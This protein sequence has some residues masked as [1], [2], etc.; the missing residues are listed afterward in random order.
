MSVEKSCEDVTIVGN[1][2]RNGGRGSWI[3][4]PRNFILADNIFVNNTTKCEPDPRRGRRSFVTGEYERYPEL[5]F[6]T[7]EPD[8][9]YGNVIVRG[10][11]FTSGSYAKHAITFAPGG[12]NL[13]VTGN[14]FHGEV[15]D[16]APVVGCENVRIDH[17]MGLEENLR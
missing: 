4:Q 3:N 6:T 13:V 8:G 14:V 10:N 15:R 16:V 1:T 11:I 7:Y 17:I 5:Y 2:F 12:N 9:K